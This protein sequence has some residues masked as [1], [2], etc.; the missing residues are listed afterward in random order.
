MDYKHLGR[1]DRNLGAAHVE[2]TPDDLSERSK[3]GGQNHR[4]RGP[5][6]EASG[7]DDKPLEHI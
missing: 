5:L 4:T 6:L 2:L 1:L 3:G 7:A